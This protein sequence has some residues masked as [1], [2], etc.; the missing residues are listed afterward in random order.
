M[1]DRANRN[2]KLNRMNFLLR[3]K[4]VNEVFISH[5]NRGIFTENI[6]RD[7]IKERFRI[8]RSTFFRYLT[9][10]YK[11]ELNDIGLI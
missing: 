6:Y 5:N 1:D 9:I 3:V 4:D 10:P 8:S 11:K 2:L 7:Y